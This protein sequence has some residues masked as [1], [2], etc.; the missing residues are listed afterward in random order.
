M[1]I[2]DICRAQYKRRLEEATKRMEM[3]NVIF[4]G[5]LTKAAKKM[6]RE[7]IEEGSLVQTEHLKDSSRPRQ[8]KQQEFLSWL[9]SD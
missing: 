4:Q 5:E 9:Y 6:L 8:H 1:L 2:T 7:A 3:E